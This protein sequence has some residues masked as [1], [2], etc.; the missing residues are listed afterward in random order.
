MQSWLAY[1][2][3]LYPHDF[4]AVYAG[5]GY[6]EMPHTTFLRKINYVCKKTDI[7]GVYIRI[8]EH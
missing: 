1:Y 6:V 7:L 2:A 4:A 5:F 8:N 3:T